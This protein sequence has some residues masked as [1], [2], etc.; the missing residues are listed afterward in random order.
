MAKTSKKSVKNTT[1]KKTVGKKVEKLI[2]DETPKDE[3]EIALDAIEEGAKQAVVNEIE[4][5]LESD[6]I[7]FGKEEGNS[8]DDPKVY[9]VKED[10]KEVDQD[11]PME[12]LND[13][14]SVLTQTDEIEVEA[15]KETF[16]EV[17]ENKSRRL[18]GSPFTYSWNGQE[19]DYIL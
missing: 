17:T 19:I 5:Q 3:M 18:N 2:I 4:E 15:M 14:A 11:P 8:W 16:K 10:F 6:D 9:E 7:P 1:T 12:M 13:D